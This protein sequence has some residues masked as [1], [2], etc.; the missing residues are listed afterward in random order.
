VA[1]EI[2]TAMAIVAMVEKM[3]S[4]GVGSLLA[5]FFIVPP[6]F[7]YLSARSIVKAL[8]LLQMQI[9][10]NEATTERVL[11][12]LGAK[13]SS[14]AEMVKD[15]E[16]LAQ[17]LSDIIRYNTRAITKLVDRIDGMGRGK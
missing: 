3:G 16:R 15:Y 1:P 12:E 9:K 2:S 13:N 4:W 7:V 8:H 11:L 6:V 5:V 17:S 14:A 10:S